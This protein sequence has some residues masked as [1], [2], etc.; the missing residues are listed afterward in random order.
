[1]SLPPDYFENVYTIDEDPFRLGSRWYEERKYAMTLAAL[2]RRRYRNALEPGCSVGILSA[3]LATRCDRLTS[4]DVVDAVVAR[5]RAGSTD[6]TVEFV[7]WSLSD[8]W[9]A[10]P[11]PFDLVVLSEVGYYLDATALR[12]ALDTMMGN[13]EP[14]ATVVCVH[15]RHHVDD[16]PLSGDDVHRI[17]AATDGLAELGR[18]TDE[19]MAIVVFVASSGGADSVAKVEGFL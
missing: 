5:N 13:L 6:D 10:V 11:G 14:N 17:A 9:S 4:T 18:Y 1:M 15:W 8:P 12:A 7:T 3:L 19:D 2:P 16:Y